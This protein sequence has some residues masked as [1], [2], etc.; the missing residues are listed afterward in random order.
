ML[1]SHSLTIVSTMN[2]VITTT[3]LKFL[4]ETFTMSTTIFN[5][6]KSSS[7]PL[8]LFSTKLKKCHSEARDRPD[9][10]QTAPVPGGSLA[11]HKIKINRTKNSKITKSNY[12]SDVTLAREVKLKK[13]VSISC[14][15]DKWIT[16]KLIKTKKCQPAVRDTLDNG[17]HPC[18]V[19]VGVPDGGLARPKS[20]YLSHVTLAAKVKLTSE[21][22]QSQVSTKT[23]KVSACCQGHTGNGPHPCGVGVGV[24]DGGLTRPQNKNKL[25]EKSK[26]NKSNY[27]SHVTQAENYKLTNKFSQSQVSIK[28]KK[29]HSEARD[30]PDLIQTAPVPGGSLAQ[31]KIK[32]NKLTSK[33]SWSQVSTKTKKFQPAVRDTLDNGPHPCSVGVGVPDG[34]LARPK[35]NYLSHVTLA[36]KVKLTSEFSQSQV[37]TK[38]IKVSA[39]CQGHT[40]NGPHPCGVGV[41]VPDSGLARPKSN[42]LS[43]VTLAVK[44]QVSPVT[45][46]RSQLSGHDTEVT[47]LRSQLSGHGEVIP[48]LLIHHISLHYFFTSVTR[49]CPPATKSH[50]ISNKTRNKLIKQ[51]NGNGKNAISVSHWNLGSKKWTN[52]RNQ[53]QA[54]VDQNQADI[55]FISEANLDELTPVYESLIQGYNITLPKTVS[56][57]GT[58][59]LVMLTKNSLDFALK[60]DLMDDVFSSIWIKISRPG[61]KSLLICGLYR[62]H[63][64]LNQDSDWSLQPVEQNRRWAQFLSQVETARISSMCH[65]IGDF[66]LDHKKWTTPDHNHLQMITE[67][68]N[69]LEAGGF[70]Q[71]VTNVTRSW[72]GQVD[73]LIDHFWTNDQCLQCSQSCGGP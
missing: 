69:T 58:A 43:H 34:G 23:I 65:I 27:L 47:V 22:S 59:R 35:S 18:S 11:R 7:T 68:K 67:T 73:T 61:V 37:S 3:I 41:G 70:F 54:L 53:I 8:S 39:C 64:Y 12:S 19:G 2:T 45:V 16:D 48:S 17:P 56:K 6:C 51:M 66:N 26:N 21:F 28:I 36:A 55:I 71:L 72:P 9:L 46:S 57:N 38:T 25:N 10:I 5:I 42:Y 33:F 15:D 62:E 13:K 63:Q 31:H 44:D 52:K 24:P 32:I 14:P 1:T 4:E 29:C 40:G 20:N 50:F 60:D 30:R 49:Y